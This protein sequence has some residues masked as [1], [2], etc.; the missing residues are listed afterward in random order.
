MIIHFLFYRCYKCNVEIPSNSSRKLLECVEFVKKHAVPNN[1]EEVENDDKSM[2][3]KSPVSFVIPPPRKSSMFM[4]PE[5]IQNSITGS[6]TIDSLPRVRVS[7][8]EHV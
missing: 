7:T 5:P 2:E 8:F 6:Y 3:N 4:N 1:K